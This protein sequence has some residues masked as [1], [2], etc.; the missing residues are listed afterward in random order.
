MGND[1]IHRVSGALGAVR[2]FLGGLL[3]AL[4]LTAS[5]PAQ[6]QSAEADEAVERR[7]DRLEAQN[8]VLEGM[9]NALDTKVDDHFVLLN[10]KIDQNA[11]VQNANTDALNDRLDTLTMVMLGGFAFILAIN[12]I[13]FAYVIHQLNSLQQS[14]Q[15]IMMHLAGVQPVGQQKT[16][17]AKKLQRQAARRTAAKRGVKRRTA[18]VVSRAAL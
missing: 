2:L 15:A 12:G 14:Q 17:T 18:A 10:A 11:E 7:L 16:Q 9:A 5:G 3:L 4:G 1:A 8:I 6:A 13:L